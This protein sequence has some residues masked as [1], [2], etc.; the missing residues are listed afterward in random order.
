MFLFSSNLYI[1]LISFLF[2]LP[3][4]RSGVMVQRLIHPITPKLVTISPGGYRGYYLLGVTSY[5]RQKFNTDQ[6]FFSGASAGAWLSLMMTY[7]GNH[8][9]LIEDMGLFS[10]GFT[11]QNLKQIQEKISDILL[12]KYTT[13]DF[14]LNRLYVGVSRLSKF[15]VETDV[16]SNFRDLEDAVRCCQA[17]SHIPFITGGMLRLYD[18]RLT[19]DGGFSVYP[20]LNETEPILHI[21]TEIWSD[22]KDKREKWNRMNPLVKN[23]RILLEQTSLFSKNK[24][25]ML[26]LYWKGYHDS[27]KNHLYL[28]GLFPELDLTRG[29]K[30]L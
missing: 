20:Y 23:I 17:S 8:T 6:C 2:V 11:N 9:T 12:E 14:D 21:C 4:F 27:A 16:Y 26:D 10:P 28:A 5:I 7:R 1:G 24:M 3:M 18:R 29:E 22:D 15:Y 25:N 19:F 13:E 30:G